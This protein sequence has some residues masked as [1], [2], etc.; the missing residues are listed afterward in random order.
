M[1][2]VALAYL[3]KP[4]GPRPVAL[5]RRVAM[6]GRLIDQLGVQGVIAL[7]P[8]FADAYLSEFITFAEL[9]RAARSRGGTGCETARSGRTADRGRARRRADR[10][11]WGTLAQHG[12]SM[13]WRSRV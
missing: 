4:P 7:Y 6:V 5:S 11:G 10:A 1:N 3:N 13:A 8:K 2:A 12:G 9:L